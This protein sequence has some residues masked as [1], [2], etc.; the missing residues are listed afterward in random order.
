MPRDNRP[1]CLFGHNEPEKVLTYL[2]VCVW[3]WFGGGGFCSRRT[4]VVS[5]GRLSLG[6]LHRHSSERGERSTER[7]KYF[8]FFSHIIPPNLQFLNQCR[9][10]QLMEAPSPLFY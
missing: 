2:E 5:N 6:T 1:V 10:L 4:R 9:T 8:G 7:K 3:L